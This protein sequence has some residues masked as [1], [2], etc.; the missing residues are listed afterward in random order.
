MTSIVKCAPPNFFVGCVCEPHLFKCA[1]VLFMNPAVRRA[2]LACEVPR[3]G[4][5]TDA[6][7]VIN[8]D[9]LVG[10]LQHMFV[11][12]EH[13]SRKAYTPRGDCI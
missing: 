10:Q 8:R 9:C 1:Q 6:D 12:L 7:T 3:G 5:D 11:S 13:S 2:V 4:G